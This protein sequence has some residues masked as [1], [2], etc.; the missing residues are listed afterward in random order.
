ME[1]RNLQDPYQRESFDKAK[2]RRKIISIQDSSNSFANQFK[3]KISRRKE[4]KFDEQMVS[5]KESDFIFHPAN[6]NGNSM[7]FDGGFSNDEYQSRSETS[8]SEEPIFEYD[9]MHRENER[10]SSAWRFFD[11]KNKKQT[12]DLYKRIL[13]YNKK[14]RYKVFNFTSCRGREGVSTIVANLVNYINLL[15]TGKKILVIDTNL[16][17]P[18]LHKVFNIPRN[19][20]G[21]TDIFNNSVGVRDAVI[22]VS[23]NVFAICCGSGNGNL[24]QD[25]F[26]KLINYFKQ[27]YSYI[28]IDCPPVISSSDA[29]SVAPSAD[30]SFLIIQSAK[31]Q[32]PVVEKAKALLQNDECEIGGIIL[33]RVQQVIP[34]WVYRFI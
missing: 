13:Y 33:N 18:N 15:S 20:Y 24:Q 30:L 28:F 7:D 34:G 26:I 11:L 23:L 32:R 3:G 9:T 10:S 29:L 14:N 4:E 2:F 27:F 21:L 12:G 16:Q 5:P 1:D 31:V 6:S 17:S 19:T 8:N 22:P 25:K